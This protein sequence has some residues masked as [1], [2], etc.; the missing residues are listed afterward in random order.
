[1]EGREDDAD[2]AWIVPWIDA[3]QAIESLFRRLDA[4]IEEE[5]CPPQLVLRRRVVDDRK[6]IAPNRSRQ[7]VVEVLESP[8]AEVGLAAEEAALRRPN[9]LGIF[10]ELQHAEDVADLPRHPLR[11]QLLR[12]GRHPSVLL[13]HSQRAIETRLVKRGHRPQIGQQTQV[14]GGLAAELLDD[15]APLETDLLVSGPHVDQRLDDLRT[16]HGITG[17]DVLDQCVGAALDPYES[18]RLRHRPPHPYL[19]IRRFH[20]EEQLSDRTLALSDKSISRLVFETPVGH[21]RDENRRVQGVGSAAVKPQSDGVDGRPNHR[22]VAIVEKLNHDV[23]G[24][25]VSHLAER[26]SGFRP[27]V[28]VLIGDQSGEHLLGAPNSP[29]IATAQEACHRRGPDVGV[30]VIEIIQ[31]QLCRVL[32]AEHGKGSHGAG[33]H[34]GIDIAHCA[35]D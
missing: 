27:H 25:R 2:G 14:P 23:A 21:Q 22:D 24:R 33:P 1:M 30:V 18:D 8:G 19:L 15:R 16:Q 35:L 29:R 20:K 3:N 34:L 11:Q 13:P 12:K 31:R 28:R 4:D 26:T 7:G 9:I 6:N 17:V 5:L 32:T 10:N